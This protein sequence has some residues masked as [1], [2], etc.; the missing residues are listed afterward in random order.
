MTTQQVNLKHDEN[1][2]PTVE[3]IRHAI[4]MRQ[5][6]HLQ[7]R[8]VRSM[9]WRDKS[10]LE[11]L[12]LIASEVG[13]A[14]NECRGE[15]PTEKLAAELADIVLRTMDL[16]EM[17]GIDLETACRAKME[18]NVKKRNWKDRAV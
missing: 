16:A 8:W 9:P 13:E 15:A 2:S 14:V 4:S 3:E 5:L 10:P 18:F 6:A 7:R 11:T 12:A 17:V 1:I